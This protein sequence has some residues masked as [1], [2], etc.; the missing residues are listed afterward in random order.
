MP[1]NSKAG[2]GF[3]SETEPLDALANSELQLPP[4]IKS[5]LANRVLTFA[6]LEPAVMDKLIAKQLARLNTQLEAQNITISLTKTVR[7]AIS[8]EG[9]NP[10]LGARLF[11]ASF[12][13]QDRQ[14]R[15]AAILAGQDTG[16]ATLSYRS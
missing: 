11:R 13:R 9:Y 14:L 3:K 1:N 4:A 10:E 12:Y 5:R 16:R 6:S 2:I 7:Q 15:L 8:E